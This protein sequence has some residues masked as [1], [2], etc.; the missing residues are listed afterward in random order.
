MD[1]SLIRKR[2]TNALKIR[3]YYYQGHVSIIMIKKFKPKIKI[4]KFGRYLSMFYICIVLPLYM[5]CS[6]IQ[7]K[8]FMRQKYNWHTSCRSLNAKQYNCYTYYILQYIHMIY[9][10]INK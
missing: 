1:V 6:L 4:N 7:K 3:L 9:N 2:L 5:H 10:I 8:R